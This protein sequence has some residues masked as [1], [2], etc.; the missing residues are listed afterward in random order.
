MRS[1]EGYIA[2]TVVYVSFYY[3]DLAARN[4]LLNNNGQAKVRR[5]GVVAVCVCV[6]ACVRVPVCGESLGK[7]INKINQWVV[8]WYLHL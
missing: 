3:R 5:K 7:M 8:F 2:C 6:R 1:E 4:I